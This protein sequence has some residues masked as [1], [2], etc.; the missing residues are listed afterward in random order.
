MA[1]VRV[2][3]SRMRV[4]E[5]QIAQALAESGSVL[6]P[7]VPAAMPIPPMPT[8]P[9]PAASGELAS[10]LV[11]DRVQIRSVGS[12]TVQA[13]RSAGTITIDAGLAATG[14]R[15]QVA[16]ALAAAGVARPETVLAVN[17]AAAMEAV[18]GF[19][20]PATL[21]PLAY[22]GAP[23]TLLDVDTAEAVI[24]HRLV[25][26]SGMERISLVQR[27]SGIGSVLVIVVDGTAVAIVDGEASAVDAGVVAMAERAA[28]ALNADVIGVRVAHVDGNAVV[29]DVEAVPEFRHAVRLG[30]V[31]VGEAIANLAL[32][33]GKHGGVSARLTHRGA[34]TGGSA[35]REG[36]HGVVLSA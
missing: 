4:E 30:E 29:W 31:G 15:L 7:V 16:S 36:Q 35:A 25:L 2:L 3:C 28:V 8:P 34:R 26:G 5:K 9:A 32:S 19:G 10:T 17:D 33:L 24:E 11:I 18:V 6:E 1:T 12:V 22:D 20:Y 27:G 21:L 14:D 23:V 13:L